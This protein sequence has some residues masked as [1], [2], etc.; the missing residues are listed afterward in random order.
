MAEKLNNFEKFER[1]KKSD[2]SPTQ[3]PSDDWL[4]ALDCLTTGLVLIN[5][6]S[7]ENSKSK[8]DTWVALYKNPAVVGWK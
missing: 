3:T 1:E 2:F 6:Q 8:F 7:L 5:T 4:G